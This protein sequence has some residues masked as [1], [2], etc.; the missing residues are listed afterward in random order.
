MRKFLAIDEGEPLLDR[1]AALAT[2]S[3]RIIIA[4]LIVFCVLKILGVI[5]WHW[6]LV[7][8]P[9]WAYILFWICVAIVIA[10]SIMRM[11]K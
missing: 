6:L 1:N 5:N 9:I 11:R 3:E 10:V 4:L 7:L 8:A 2:I